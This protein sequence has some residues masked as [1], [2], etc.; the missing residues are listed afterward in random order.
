M[1]LAALAV[2]LVL[3]RD[4]GVTFAGRPQGYWFPRIVWGGDSGELDT[5]RLEQLRSG[6]AKTLPVLLE[7]AQSR[8]TVLT[9]K[10]MAAHG[11]LPPW[12]G[13]LLP[14]WRDDV[15]VHDEARRILSGL[16]AERPAA[17]AFLAR[18]EEWPE[19]FKQVWLHR[20]TPEFGA[21]FFRAHEW[22]HR[23]TTNHQDAARWIERALRHDLTAAER[24]G[25]LARALECPDAA[26]DTGVTARDVLI[27]LARRGTNSAWAAPWMEHWLNSSHRSLRACGRIALAAM[28]P[29]KHPLVPALRASHGLM[30]FGEWGVTLDP[31]VVHATLTTLPWVAWAEELAEDLDLRVIGPSPARAPEGSHTETSL[32]VYFYE[33]L[34]TNMGPRSTTSLPRLMARAL[35]GNAPSE[36]RAVARILAGQR[37]SALPTLHEWSQALSNPVTAAPLVL[38]LASLGPA[39]RAAEP[40]LHRVATG[41]WPLKLPPHDRPGFQLPPGLMKRHGLP[42]KDGDVDDRLISPREAFDL[43]LSHVWPRGLGEGSLQ[44]RTLPELAQEAL[45]R[46]RGE[47]LADGMAAPPP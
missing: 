38:L 11:S 19:Y 41:E 47:A 43:R 16:V 30:T 17:E 3:F 7:A 34:G 35:D 6:G 12:L 42:P 9:T 21:E 36:A 5:L 27:H 2:A 44:S 25:V 31:S 14:R 20:P 10:Y 23:A 29:E 33:S 4:R 37:Y 46:V 40:E 13:R 15:R 18:F 39:A 1:A 28:A 45:R 24:E 32:L 8:D 22:P 26:W